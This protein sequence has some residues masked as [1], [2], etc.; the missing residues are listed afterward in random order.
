MC[1][2]TNSVQDIPKGKQ[3]FPYSS[4][5]PQI[6]CQFHAC[7]FAFHILLGSSNLDCILSRHLTNYFPKTSLSLWEFPLFLSAGPHS[8]I[9]LSPLIPLSCMVYNSSS[10]LRKGKGKMF[11]KHG[12]YSIHIYDWQSWRRIL[13]WKLFS[14]KIFKILSIM[15]PVFFVIYN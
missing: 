15:F 2:F 3:N 6:I 7:L 8:H 11:L 12:F 5:T 10:F 14:L 4:A 9:F 13:R 1:I